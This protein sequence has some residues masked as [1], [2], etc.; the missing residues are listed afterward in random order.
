MVLNVSHRAPMQAA[1]CQGHDNCKG[2]FS[3]DSAWER[4]VQQDGVHIVNLPHAQLGAPKKDPKMY[5]LC[6]HEALH[7]SKWDGVVQQKV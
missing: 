1:A 2:Y 4:R 5:K 3:Y 6:V 7:Q